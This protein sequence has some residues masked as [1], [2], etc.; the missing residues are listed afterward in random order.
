MAD[1]LRI[2]P[3]FRM[4]AFSSPN[5]G[6]VPG[7]SFLQNQQGLYYTDILMVVDLVLGAN[8]QGDMRFDQ[9]PVTRTQA[10]KIAQGRPRGLLVAQMPGRCRR[11]R[12]PVAGG[13]RG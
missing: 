10:G 5:A 2:A 9:T 13:Q 7:A 1:E 8:A 3:P 12:R 4:W 6:R 11:F